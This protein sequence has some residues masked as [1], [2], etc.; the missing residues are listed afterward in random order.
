MQQECSKNILK[1]VLITRR[2]YFY[3]RKEI[4]YVRFR[5][6]FTGK[7]L[8][9]KSTGTDDREKA[10]YIAQKWLHEGIPQSDR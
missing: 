7:I 2:F 10:V 3:K 4:Y 8:P 5:N 1:G 9:G 6:P